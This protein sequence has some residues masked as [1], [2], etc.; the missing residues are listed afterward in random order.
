MQKAIE[1]EGGLTCLLDMLALI[2][3]HYASITQVSDLDECNFES[4]EYQR[5]PGYSASTR[6]HM[7]R[8]CVPMLNDSGA[9]CSAITEEMAVILVN[10]TNR[11][12]EEGLISD[13]SYN[14]PIRQ[15]YR[16]ASRIPK[17]CFKK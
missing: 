14:Y 13:C 5:P 1:G 16:Y 12:V 15:I 4:R 11:M 10:H 2:N 6:V 17:T 8:L 7:G 3:P 9:T